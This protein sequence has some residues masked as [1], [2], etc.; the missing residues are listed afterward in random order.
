[1]AKKGNRNIFLFQCSVC[2]NK[3]YTGTKNTV[4][5]KEKLALNKFC[6]HDRK[7]TPHN[8]VKI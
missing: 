8:E 1:M 4:N 3:N 5:I 2:K 6:S 7:T